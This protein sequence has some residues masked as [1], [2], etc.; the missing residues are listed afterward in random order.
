[1][2]SRDMVNT[3]SKDLVVVNTSS[4]DMVATNTSS[5]NLVVVKTSISKDRGVVYTDISKD[6]VVLYTRDKERKLRKGWSSGLGKKWGELLL[7]PKAT[8]LHPNLV[9]LLPVA[10][11]CLLV[12]N[13]LRTGV[14]HRTASEVDS[15][16]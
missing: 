5:K 7:R 6:W 3:N 8:K 11:Q 1:M 13:L 4:R 16:G 12:V 2:S 15:L 10:Q 14:D 9:T